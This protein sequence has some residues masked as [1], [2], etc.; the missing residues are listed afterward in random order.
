[1]S[2]FKNVSVVSYYVKDWEKA[3]KFYQETLE[4]PVIFISDEA[5]WIE[6]GHE[7]AAHVAINRWDGPD[8][9][10]PRNGGGTAVL[11]VEDAKRVT[12]AL[13]VRGVR[14]DDAIEIPGMVCYG[15]LYDPEGNRIQFASNPSS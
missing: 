9:I 12:S 4:W 8:P 3:K 14:C 6:Y 10:P 11:A 1:M 2:L 7:N 15:T 5:G 13:R